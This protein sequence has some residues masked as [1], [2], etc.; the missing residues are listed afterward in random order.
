MWRVP[1][2]GFLFAGTLADNLRYGIPTPR[3]SG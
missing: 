1:Q 3:R 2:E